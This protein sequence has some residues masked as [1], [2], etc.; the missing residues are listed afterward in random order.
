M[1]LRIGFGITI[2]GEAVKKLSLDFREQNSHVPWKQ[3]AGMRD[4]LVHDY[5]QI[6]IKQVSIVTQS[7]IPELLQNLQS[8]LPQIE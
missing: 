8:L 3:I 5:R 7:D 6:N 1:G 4:K 2:I